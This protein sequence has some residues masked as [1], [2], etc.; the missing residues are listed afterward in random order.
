M[1]MTKGNMFL[2]SVHYDLIIFYVGK[3][4][5]DRMTSY[6]KDIIVSIGLPQ[7]QTFG[8]R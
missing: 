7:D 3:L 8:S 2:Y 1:G 4:E 5:C 6:L